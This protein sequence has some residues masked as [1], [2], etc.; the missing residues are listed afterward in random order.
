MLVLGRKRDES[1]MLGDDIEVTVTEISKDKCRI[2]ISAPKAVLVL[3]R[4]LWDAS[5]REKQ[6]CGQPV[7]AGGGI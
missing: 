5:Q 7:A 6:T 1:I 3:R 2:G 4:E